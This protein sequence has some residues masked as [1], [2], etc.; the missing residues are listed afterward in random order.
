[1]TTILLW[2]SALLLWWYFNSLHRDYWIDLTRQRLFIIRDTLFD[3]ALAGALPMDGDAYRLMRDT[4]NGMIRYTHDISLSGALIM[5]MTGR[6]TQMK[7]EGTKYETAYVEATRPLSAEGRL[8]IKRARKNMHFMIVIHM[9]HTSA[10]LWVLLVPL[11]NIDKLA[12]KAEGLRQ[13]VTRNR[14]QWR[15]FDAVAYC[16]GNDGK[17]AHC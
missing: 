10:V 6:F 7:A 3:D 15:P 17:T 13:F 14:R 11:V 4:L 5:K 2:L 16:L 12:R 1:M 9:I 8:A